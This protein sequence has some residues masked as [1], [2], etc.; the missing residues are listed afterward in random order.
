MIR[1]AI[2]IRNYFERS[3]ERRKIGQLARVSFSGWNQVERYEPE[4][5]RGPGG[6]RKL[7]HRRRVL[8]SDLATGGVR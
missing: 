6:E 4:G 2:K 5:S 1:C 8:K 7:E 3:G